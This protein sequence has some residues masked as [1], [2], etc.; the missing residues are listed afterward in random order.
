MK[1]VAKYEAFDEE[2]HR[3]T[4]PDNDQFSD[5]RLDDDS[6]SIEAKLEDRYAIYITKDNIEKFFNIISQIDW[7]DS[8]KSISGRGDEYFFLIGRKLYHSNKPYFGE[9]LKVYNPQF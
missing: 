2:P 3:A 1:W 6:K 9:K 7:I 4:N 5:N 8:V